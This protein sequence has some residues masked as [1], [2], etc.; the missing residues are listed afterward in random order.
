VIESAWEFFVSG[1]PVMW[2][3]VGLSVWLWSLVVLETV[4]VWRAGRERLEA[5]QAV[6]AL[7]GGGQALE[8]LGPRAR[9]VAALARHMGSGAEELWWEAAVR[10]EMGQMGRRVGP[11]IALGAAAPLL[12]LLGTVRG[13]IGTFEAICLFGTG[14]VHALASGIREALI[15]TQTGLMVAIPALVAGYGLHR[16]VE[17]QRQGLKAFA[18]A[19][20]RWLKEMERADA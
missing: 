2:P 20:G 3:L 5:A 18:E 12:G 4:D 9:A 15:T 7:E 19:V 6:R 11:I 8:G 16:A 17:R 1:G 14:N 13:M 10:R